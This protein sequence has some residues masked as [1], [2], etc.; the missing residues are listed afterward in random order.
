LRTY[1]EQKIGKDYINSCLTIYKECNFSEFNIIGS[2]IY[3]YD[4]NEMNICFYNPELNQI[5]VKQFWSCEK[6]DVL[7]NE[8]NKLLLSL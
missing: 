2:Y 8:I 3:L 6:K 7:I 5:P 1:I 4:K